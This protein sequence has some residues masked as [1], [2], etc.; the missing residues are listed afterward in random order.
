M[1]SLAASPLD[2]MIVLPYP[3][4]AQSVDLERGQVIL[5]DLHDFHI[6]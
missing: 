3:L 6:E 4:N 5:K 2:R 1:N